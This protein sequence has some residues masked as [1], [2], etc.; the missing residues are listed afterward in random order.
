VFKKSMISIKVTHS[1]MT[2]FAQKY[3]EFILKIRNTIFHYF[4][5][6]LQQIRK[7]NNPLQVL[8]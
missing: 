2:I 1:Y 8:N 5:I 3:R 6:K 7:P 4:F